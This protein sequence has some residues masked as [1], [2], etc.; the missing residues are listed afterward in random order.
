MKHLAAIALLAMSIMALTLPLPP[1]PAHASKMQP[2][3][4]AH[5]G[6][7]GL[8]A[9]TT[10]R[11]PRFNICQGCHVNIRMRVKQ[12]SACGFNFQS[13]GPFAGQE[14]VVRPQNGIFGSADQT[15]YA[16]RPNSGY[17]GQD[18]FETRLYFEEGNG[19]R[20]F[21]YLGVNVMVVPSL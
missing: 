17:L 13:L 12:D 3:M 19:K 15:T 16:Y 4:M 11:H 6:R 7:F 21:M 5:K 10:C 1:E 9:N 8:N 18:H 20:T 14:I 2:G